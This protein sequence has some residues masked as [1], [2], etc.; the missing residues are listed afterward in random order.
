MKRALGMAGLALAGALMGA[1]IAQAGEVNVYSY[2]QEFLIRP[3]LETFTEE[4]GIQVNVVFA[5]QGVLERLKAEGDQSPADIVLTVDVAR[6]DALVEADLLQ[7]VTSPVLERNIPPQY[8]HPDG[9]WFGLTTRA[10]IIY[11]SKERVKPGAITS[12]EELADPKWEGRVCMRSAKHEYNRALL[13]SIIAAHG[14]EK[15]LGW[16]KGLKENLA[17]KPQ[18]NDRGQVKAIKEGL[19][20]VALGNS[21]YYGAMKFNDENPEQKE[22][23]A[24]VRLVFPNQDGRGTHVNISGIAM[25]KSSRN[26]DD[27]IKLMEFLSKETAQRMYASA[28]YEYP[29]NPRVAPDPEV[30]SWGSFKA[31]TL[32]LQT[33]ADLSP[34][35]AR[36]FNEAGLD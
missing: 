4:T 23:A 2:R 28:N 35:A 26:Q 24:A 12:Y 14:E 25:T 36:M 17:R 15:A 10:R 6:L 32:P 29:V 13:A 16:V 1:T 27:A 5:K 30:A 33:V 18:G 20:D 7:P 34:R 3:F 9:L 21:Y 31:D 8:R 19:C 11:A 22:W